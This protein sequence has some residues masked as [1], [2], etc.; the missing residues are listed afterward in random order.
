MFS[1]APE[2]TGRLL[3]C[4]AGEGHKAAKLKVREEKVAGVNKVGR[5]GGTT[6]RACRRSAGSRH[7]LLSAFHLLIC[8][9]S[10][11]D[12]CEQWKEE[13]N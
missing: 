5:V 4:G 11:Y 3:W 7:L 8:G 2:V 13:N 1:P 12:T 9:A 10:K 6:N